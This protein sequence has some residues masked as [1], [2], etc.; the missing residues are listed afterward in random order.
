MLRFEC[1][2]VDAIHDLYQ[3]FI[4]KCNAGGALIPPVFGY[5]PNDFT[6]NGM[7][8]RHYEELVKLYIAAVNDICRDCEKLES[9]TLHTHIC[10]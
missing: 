1:P 4:A 8:H 7:H 6:P 5:R 10:L 3:K 2:N 9:C